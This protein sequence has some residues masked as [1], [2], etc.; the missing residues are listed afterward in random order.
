MIFT[1]K[2]IEQIKAVT[3]T[4]TRRVNRGKYQVGKDYSVQPGRGRKG[5]PNLRIVMDEI[6]EEVVTFTHPLHRLWV[7]KPISVKDALAEGRY[8]PEE[9]EEEFLRLYPKWD[10]T[11]RW[12]F[13]FHVLEVKCPI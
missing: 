12:V 4:Q 1:P 7:E 5:I 10:G 3:K 9:Y 11:K 2:H 13:K 8:T 6:I